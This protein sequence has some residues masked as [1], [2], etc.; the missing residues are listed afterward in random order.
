MTGREMS[1]PALIGMIVLAGVIV[2][3]A[4]VMVDYINQLRAK[5][6]SR[7]D[8]ILLAVSTRLRPVLMTS[9]TTILGLIPM[10]IGIGTGSEMEAPLATVMVGGLL[11]GTI[12]TLVVVPV[13]YTI[14]E[15]LLLRLK[16]KFSSQ[17]TTIQ[18]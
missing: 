1:V 3:N 14:L 7:R 15:D 12:L 16:S 6:L 18:G 10:A 2:N 5:G 4:I 11:V 8:A 13:V 17:S 9:L